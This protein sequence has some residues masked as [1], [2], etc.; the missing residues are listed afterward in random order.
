MR[1]YTEFQLTLPI[2]LSGR[3]HHYNHQRLRLRGFKVTQVVSQIHSIRHPSF[4]CFVN[5]K[6]WICSKTFYSL[7]LLERR[8]LKNLFAVSYQWGELQNEKGTKQC[9]VTDVLI[10]LVFVII[11][12]C[13]RVVNHHVVYGECMQ[14][15]FVSYTSRKLD[16]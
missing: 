7:C 6:M 5:D 3:Y 14:S 13:I 16:R 12:R 4:K 1:L 9:A 2:D 8:S 11:S 10:N 15:S